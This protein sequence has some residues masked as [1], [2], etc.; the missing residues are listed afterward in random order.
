MLFAGMGAYSRALTT[1]FNGYGLGDPVTVS[2]PLSRYVLRSHSVDR[3]LSGSGFRRGF[4][5]KAKM[6]R[7]REKCLVRLPHVIRGFMF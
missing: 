6:D 7:A 3:C 1:Q 4:L 5:A 2:R